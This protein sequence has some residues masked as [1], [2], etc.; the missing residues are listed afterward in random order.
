MGSRHTTVGCACNNV[1][2]GS[3]KA[4]DDTLLH[5]ATSSVETAVRPC[6]PVG[7]LRVGGR[8]MTYISVCINHLPSF[9][10]HSAPQ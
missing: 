4:I 6:M 1:P 10:P 3:V 9:L 8:W 7:V 5:F 2:T